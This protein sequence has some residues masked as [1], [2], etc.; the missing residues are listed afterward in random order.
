MRL[1]GNNFTPEKDDLVAIMW[2]WRASMFCDISIMLQF[3]LREE[4]V[5]NYKTKQ[6]IY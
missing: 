2:K 3:H 5:Q 1:Q 6:V 4:G